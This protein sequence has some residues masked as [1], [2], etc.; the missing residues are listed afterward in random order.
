MRPD[1]LVAAIRQRLDE[2]EVRGSLA[3]LLTTS[4]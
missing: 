1:E 3:C 4:Q 2:T